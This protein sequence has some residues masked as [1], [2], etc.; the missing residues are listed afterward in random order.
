M[1]TGLLKTAT[2]TKPPAR[3]TFD[4]DDEDC[5]DGGVEGEEDEDEDDL[6][7]HQGSG[8]RIVGTNGK[9]LMGGATTMMNNRESSTNSTSS[10]KASNSHVSTTSQHIGNAP[11]DPSYA[12]L[13]ALLHSVPG[14]SL[15]QAKE[16]ISR[17]S[18]GKD[19]TSPGPPSQTST[20]SAN[21]GYV[22]IDVVITKLIEIERY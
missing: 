17:K 5:G 11:P 21:A 3:N 16:W 15:V 18:N 10:G 13:Y 7:R 12:M 4:D 9:H 22:F 2:L 1:T 8:S 19:G 20:S 14:K 6:E